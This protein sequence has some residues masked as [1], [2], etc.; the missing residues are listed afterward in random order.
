MKVF[1]ADGKTVSHFLVATPC[2]GLQGF[3]PGGQK[4]EFF[5]IFSIFLLVVVLFVAENCFFVRHPWCYLFVNSF[6]TATYSAP[7]FSKMANAARMGCLF[8]FFREVKK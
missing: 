4:L 2:K 6:N 1:C 7:I 8:F 3:S 5:L